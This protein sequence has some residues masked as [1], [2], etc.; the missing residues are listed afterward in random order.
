MGGN[1]DDAHLREEEPEELLVEPQKGTCPQCA[2][3][4]VPPGISSKTARTSEVRARDSESLV[5]Y[6]LFRNSGAPLA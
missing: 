1:R 6:S 2:L 5:P 3:F 4:V